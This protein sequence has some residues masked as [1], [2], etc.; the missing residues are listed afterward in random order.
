MV[1]L[2]IVS[3]IVNIITLPIQDVIAFSLPGPLDK[4]FAGLFQKPSNKTEPIQVLHTQQSLGNKS[5]TINF[6]PLSPSP[7]SS[8]ASFIIPSECHIEMETCQ[9]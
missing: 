6:L 3:T 4:I 9:I 1:R 5:T 8:S 7:L 2:L